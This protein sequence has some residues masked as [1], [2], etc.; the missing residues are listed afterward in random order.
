MTGTDGWMDGWMDVWMYGWR[1][2]GVSYVASVVNVPLHHVSTVATVHGCR[3]LKVHFAP[4][5]QFSDC[6]KR[7]R[8]AQGL[9]LRAKALLPGISSPTA[10]N[11]RGV[12]RA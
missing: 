2:G 12:L 4:R 7:T 3:A 5:D 8:S 11:A 1:D 9:G 10:A 6:S